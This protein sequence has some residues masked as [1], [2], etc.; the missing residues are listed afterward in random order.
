LQTN[1]VNEA[2][3]KDHVLILCESMDE[4]VSLR[5]RVLR[6]PDDWRSRNQL[7]AL[8]AQ[9][10]AMMGDLAMNP[11]QRKALAVGPS[12]VRGRLAELRAVRDDAR[13]A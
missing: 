11:A 7:R 2:I 13:G 1:W 12:E 9:I 6:D 10:N 5:V 8:D 4:R 3:D